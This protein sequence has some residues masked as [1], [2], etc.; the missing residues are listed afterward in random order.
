MIKTYNYEFTYENYPV[1]KYLYGK[2]TAY[3]LQES[4]IAAMILRDWF[5]KKSVNLLELCC[6]SR[7]HERG[8]IENY[9]S[10]LNYKGLDLNNDLADYNQDIVKMDLPTRFNAILAAYFTI[11]TFSVKDDKNNYGITRDLLVTLFK[12]CKDHLE[13]GGCLIV[14]YAC[15][16]LNEDSDMDWFDLA[17]D[18]GDENEDEIDP[19]IH[20]ELF[21][22][23]N[24]KK[25][26][27]TISCVINTTYN[28]ETGCIYH[29]MNKF[30]VKLNKQIVAKV[31][32][33]RPVIFRFWAE[34]EVIDAA[35]E[36]GF[37]KFKFYSVP[38]MHSAQ[39]VNREESIVKHF[40]SAQK[41][42]MGV[43]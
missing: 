1:Y 9:P 31:V 17:D 41:I 24:L 10:Y 5:G 36:A 18:N 35:R 37:N 15:Y 43:K 38:D 30:H 29:K 42:V 26:P 40:T 34:S 16:P 20:S 23:F 2:S 11:Q 27:H 22:Y 28:R 6:G 32:V 3:S 14:D 13:K 39:V 19:I 8:L 4:T 12:N 33:K 25:V 7:E 21:D